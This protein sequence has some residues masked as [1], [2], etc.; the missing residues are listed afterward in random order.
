MNSIH[1][2]GENDK[3]LNGELDKLS[4]AYV[5]LEQDEPPE[6][7]DQAI[8]NSA[9]RALEKKP[10]WMKFGW[11]HGLTTTA[12]FVLAF[13]LILNQPESTPILED[14]I[15]NNETMRLESGKVAKKQAP[16]VKYLESLPDELNL[17]MK[18]KDVVRQDTARD[19]PVAAAPMS[20]VKEIKSGDRARHSASEAQ[21]SLRAQEGLLE[22][23][24]SLDQ[25]AE[26]S[27]ILQEEIASDEADL[28]LDTLKTD[29]AY[30][31]SQPRAVEEPVLGEAESR[32]N[33]KPGIEQE[34]LAI[35][36]MKQ[37]G[38]SQWITE[39]ELFKERYPDYPLP[40]A[41]HQVP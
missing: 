37:A 1:N 18:T 2:N 34:L 22:K 30:E 35:I 3:S 40:D 39:L 23:Y 15:S 16:D 27:G 24:E 17:E 29:A 10:H 25:D 21:R 9:H 41:L 13:S 28:M 19:L 8:L 36:E 33:E 11:L 5:R 12:V 14:G 31:M 6:L 38:D 26:V 7:L 4:S 32:V 20:V